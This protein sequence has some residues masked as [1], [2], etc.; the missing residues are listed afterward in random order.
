MDTLANGYL[1]RELIT[2]PQTQES[3]RV[4]EL[5]ERFRK[6]GIASYRSSGKDEYE[7]LLSY[8]REKDSFRY[9]FVR[10][11]YARSK[12]LIWRLMKV[13]IWSPSLPMGY[14]GAPGFFFDYLGEE[15]LKEAQRIADL[16]LGRRYAGRKMDDE[17]MSFRKVREEY[18]DPVE[19]DKAYLRSRNVVDLKWPK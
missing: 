2:G 9:A 7:S 5:K 19:E 10:C 16:L 1:T 12:N 13:D 18:V 8:L 15:P 3:L 6:L 4:L 17:R 14:F 11:P